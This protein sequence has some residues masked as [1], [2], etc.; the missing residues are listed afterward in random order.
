MIYLPI[1]H[2][3]MKNGITIIVIFKVNMSGGIAVWIFFLLLSTLFLVYSL[4]DWHPLI[5]QRFSTEI[6]LPSLC[7]SQYVKKS[8]NS[9][10]C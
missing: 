2:K 1:I 4:T 7:F 10:L 6:N 3:Y 5:S 9:I 8:E